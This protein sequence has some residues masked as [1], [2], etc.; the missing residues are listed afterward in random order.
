MAEEDRDRVGLSAWYLLAATDACGYMT[1][2]GRWVPG[3]K[4]LVERASGGQIRED[5]IKH[6]LRKSKASSASS[7]MLSA[8]WARDAQAA[9]PSAIPLPDERSRVFSTLLHEHMPQS[10]TDA[11]LAAGWLVLHDGFLVPTED[12][13]D[14]VE[15]MKSEVMLERRTLA[16]N[17]R[18][19]SQ[20]PRVPRAPVAT[21][22][23]I[24]PVRPMCP[25][26]LAP[27]AADRRS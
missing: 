19:T 15:L 10:A 17:G 27:N 7:P 23:S 1:F 18:Q 21:A 24:V 22:N 5:R 8:G 26:P 25:M 6:L 20:T 2:R 13:G 16:A 12:M 14:A 4:F 9:L 11:F 3:A